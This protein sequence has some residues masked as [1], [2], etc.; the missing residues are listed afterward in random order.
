MFPNSVIDSSLLL[1]GPGHQTLNDYRG[2]TS[3]ILSQALEADAWRY[4]MLKRP[5]DQ[6]VDAIPYSKKIRLMQESSLHS[7][8]ACAFVNGKELLNA[9]TNQPAIQPA[10]NWAREAALTELLLQALPAGNRIP[11]VFSSIGFRTKL[12]ESESAPKSHNMKPCDASN[13]AGQTKHINRERDMGA[14]V[15]SKYRGVSWHKR[16]KSWTARIWKNGS[17]EHLGT[18]PTE[19]RAGLAVD[20]KSE[21][22]FGKHFNDF[23]FRDHDERKLLIKALI[24]EPGDTLPYEERKKRRKNRR[25]RVKGESEHDNE[26]NKTLSSI[27]KKLIAAQGKLYPSYE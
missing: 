12:Q 23:N 27:D 25:K 2:N 8:K 5:A 21:A 20:I 16:D 7:N 9:A 19:V 15:K 1:A 6:S 22:Y 3:A 26:T 14:S 4:G 18:F 13:D 17:S 10:Y 24:E 11:S